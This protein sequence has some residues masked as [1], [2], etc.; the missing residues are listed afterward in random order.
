VGEY[1]K[2]FDMAGS[3]YEEFSN[4][5]EAALNEYWIIPSWTFCNLDGILN[6]NQWELAHCMGKV[7]KYYGTQKEMEN[8][9][10][11]F[12]REYWDSVDQDK[13]GLGQVQY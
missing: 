3:N 9:I 12:A 13:D 6:I 2:V 7:A 5:I 11:A 1:A 4:F 10:L 8:F